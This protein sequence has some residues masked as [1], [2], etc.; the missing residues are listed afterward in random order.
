MA[1][2]ASSLSRWP[3]SYPEGRRNRTKQTNKQK[4]VTATITTISYN[5]HDKVFVAWKRKKRN[6][7]YDW[8]GDVEVQFFFLKE[9]TNVR[10]NIA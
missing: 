1:W 8:M 9:R 10:I 7:I 3:S 4:N 5:D 6:T 2:G